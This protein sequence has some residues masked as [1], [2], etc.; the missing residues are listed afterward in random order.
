[1]AFFL[2]NEL[3]ASQ[4]SLQTNMFVM[5]AQR[6]RRACA[7]SNPSVTAHAKTPIL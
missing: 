7:N 4:Q 6:G 1:M 2:I 5:Y 3:T